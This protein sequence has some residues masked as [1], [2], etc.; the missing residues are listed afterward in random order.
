MLKLEYFARERE[1]I[2]LR[3]LKEKRR[4]T[5]SEL[6]ELFETSGTTIRRQ[7]R[8]MEQAGLLIRTHGGAISMEEA[9]ME[10]SLE[11]KTGHQTLEKQA[12]AREARRHVEDGDILMLGG[13]TS[14]V[15]FAKLLHDARNLIV[16]TNSLPVAA[17]LY[18][19]KDIEVQ[20]C[21][22]AIREKSG[23]VIGPSAVRFLEELSAVKTFVGADSISIKYGI[24]TPNSFEAEIERML[25]E[26]G[27]TVFVLADSTK[28]D[29]ITLA[30]QSPLDTIN[31]I[32]TDANIN[33]GF[34]EKLTAAGVKVII[35]K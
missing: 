33:P 31:C 14:V 25:I 26:R 35:A 24:T 34:R 28:M 20:I 16:I 23:V 5:V 29:K 30:R 17:E 22:G 2:I 9:S 19:Q 3:M 13:G 11:T 27:K 8:E 6:S 4:I 15:E 21:G 10:R 7:L 18:P 32:I 12:I 1:Q